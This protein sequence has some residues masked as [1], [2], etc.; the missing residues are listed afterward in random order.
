[1]CVNLP[2]FPTEYNIRLKDNTLSV[3]GI[4]NASEM[5]EQAND[6]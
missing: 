5:V 2:A 6:I 3:I 1:M 4:Q